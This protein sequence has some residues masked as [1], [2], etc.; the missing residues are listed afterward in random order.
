MYKKLNLNKMYYIYFKLLDIILG[1]VIMF[2][3]IYFND[4]EISLESIK[5]D[6]NNP[7][8]YLVLATSFLVSIWIRFSVLKA[9]KKT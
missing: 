8:I 5:G 2:C 4:I 1:T 7:R 6:L 3:S 9:I